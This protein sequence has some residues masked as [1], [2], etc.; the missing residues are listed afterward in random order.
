M[1]L[2]PRLMSLVLS[3]IVLALLVCLMLYCKKIHICRGELF[4]RRYTFPQCLESLNL[5]ALTIAINDGTPI[6]QVVA[7][8]K[9]A[10]CLL[11][12]GAPQRRE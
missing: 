6:E 1:I 12:H 5:L 4:Y 9:V 2:V 3:N 10:N 7:L 11:H 8:A